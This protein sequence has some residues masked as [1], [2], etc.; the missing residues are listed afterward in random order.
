MS[1]MSH[2]TLIDAMRKLTGLIDAEIASLTAE[3]PNSVSAV[4]LTDHMFDLSDKTKSPRKVLWNP[5]GFILLSDS[6]DASTMEK[7]IKYLEK[8]IA[9]LSKMGREGCFDAP[10]FALVKQLLASL[11]FLKSEKNQSF[12]RAIQTSTLEVK[13]YETLKRWMDLLF[14]LH[15]ALKVFEN[16]FEF[17]GFSSQES[18]RSAE[19]KASYLESFLS[20]SISQPTS[21][22]ALARELIHPKTLEIT[23][24][25][26]W[27][28]SIA[29]GLS[30]EE[31]R[32]LAL[33]YHA[34]MS[35]ADSEKILDAAL[36]IM[37]A[38]SRAILQEIKND[39][40]VALPTHRERLVRVAEKKAKIFETYN[41]FSMLLAVHCPR[42][43]LDFDQRF[44]STLQ[45]VFSANH[46]INQNSGALAP[47][48][49]RKAYLKFLLIQQIVLT[50]GNAFR[51]PV[52]PNARLHLDVVV[53]YLKQHR[54]WWGRLA[55]ALFGYQTQTFR[56]YESY[57]RTLDKN[58]SPERKHTL[59]DFI[60][61]QVAL[62]KE[63]LKKGLGS[64]VLP[65]LE[66]RFFNQ[67]Q[68]HPKGISLAHRVSAEPCAI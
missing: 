8:S 60:Q 53:E 67:I 56:V 58:I 59:T 1:G 4:T 22:Y 49:L 51:S 24:G 17:I 68:L 57:Q 62:K 27:Q 6:F 19:L 42:K 44:Q 48:R 55:H 18:G 38:G 50:G 2:S 15:K 23:D 5:S 35:L 25:V 3:N 13:H 32:K 28:T 46:L 66:E 43:L 41:Y 54:N 65:F 31:K 34:L 45:S 64:H 9:D 12:W 61:T 29:N 26:D 10:D 14:R 20:F 39:L 63:Q 36:E 40:T 47:L 30:Q 37:L 21:H 11:T 16:S 52:E 33:E 7:K